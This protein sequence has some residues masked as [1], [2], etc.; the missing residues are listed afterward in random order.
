M[1]LDIKSYTG[2]GDILFTDSKE[3]IV[4]KLKQYETD[5]INS[6]YIAFKGSGL[7]VCFDSN[8]VCQCVNIS[9]FSY[10]RSSGDY[11]NVFLDNVNLSWNFTKVFEQ[12]KGMSSNYQEYGDY[13][14]NFVFLDIGICISVSDINVE[15]DEDGNETIIYDEDWSGIAVFRKDFDFITGFNL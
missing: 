3:N 7:I 1:K 6:E 15:E 11:S 9:G 5:Q 4:L 12:L 13:T 2:V 10:G 14:K 8:N